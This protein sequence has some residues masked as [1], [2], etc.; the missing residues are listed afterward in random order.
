MAY[1]YRKYYI[2]Y[3]RDAVIYA[4]F[5][6]CKKKKKLETKKF[7]A[8]IVVADPDRDAEGENGEKRKE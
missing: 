1:Y 7:Q 4:A 2:F 5:R 8:T 3:K 6:L